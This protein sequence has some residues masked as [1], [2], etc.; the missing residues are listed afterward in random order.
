MRKR[1][2]DPTINKNDWMSYGKKTEALPS[3]EAGIASF[4]KT[5]EEYGRLRAIMEAKGSAYNAVT[6]Q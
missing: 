3:A 6:A 4:R 1:T 5:G 2:D